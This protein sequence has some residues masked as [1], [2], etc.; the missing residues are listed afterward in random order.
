M[1]ICWVA[2]S[3]ICRASEART[4][5]ARSAYIGRP[6]EIAVNAAAPPSRV[7][8]SQPVVWLAAE[9]RAKAPTAEQIAIGR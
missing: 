9:P 6:T 8:N 2:R 5:A 7:Q 3:A 1:R 4:D